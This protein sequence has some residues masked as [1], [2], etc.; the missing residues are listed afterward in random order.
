MAKK[1]EEE[2]KNS[3]TKKSNQEKVKETEIVIE[4]N[5]KN[6]QNNNVT[7]TIILGLVGLILILIPDAFN[8]I[9]GYLVGIVLL[10]VGLIGI[11]KYMKNRDED[12][13]L[14]LVTGILYAVLG[15]IIMAYPH[16]VI[17]LASKCLGVYLV[18][19][20]ILKLQTAFNLKATNSKW[21]GTLVVGILVLVLGALLIF[22][23]FSGVTV[24]KLAGAFLIA[25]AV[26]DLID[27]YI[28]QKSNS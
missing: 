16:S 21:I 12:N 26:F 10:V 15:V 23:P 25:Y 7:L 27:I 28:I 19:S 18:I 20:S 8:K 3:K 6:K 4:K 17:N 13:A 14:N 9:I 5:T 22:N 24:T 2:K 1:N 11:Y